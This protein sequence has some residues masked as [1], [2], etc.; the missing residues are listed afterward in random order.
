MGDLQSQRFPSV[1][2]G[3]FEQPEDEKPAAIKAKRKGTANSTS[4]KTRK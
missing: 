4:K 2:I 3:R 1:A